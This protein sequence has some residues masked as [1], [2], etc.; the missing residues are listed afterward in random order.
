M[1]K[2]HANEHRTRCN[3][4]VQLKVQTKVA[5]TAHQ[6][7]EAN[8]SFD[9]RGLISG[10]LRYSY[11]LNYTCSYRTKEGELFGSSLNMRNSFDRQNYVQGFRLTQSLVK[12]FMGP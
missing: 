4:S 2:I 3:I 5:I 8:Y 12:K 1:A 11:S 7:I 6:Y 9:L 10:T